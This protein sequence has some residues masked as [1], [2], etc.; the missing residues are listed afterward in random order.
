MSRQS[1]E[2]HK[3]QDEQQQNH[4]H[5]PPYPSAALIQLNAQLIYEDVC[6]THDPPHLVRICCL[7]QR[8][9]TECSQRP[10]V[11]GQIL[12]RVDDNP[13]NPPQQIRLVRSLSADRILS[14]H[15]ATMTDT[16]QNR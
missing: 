1:R 3:D 10:H 6:I 15:V 8:M 5:D 14:V 13:G 16:P 7:C 2:H 12:S 9:T 4:R 11:I